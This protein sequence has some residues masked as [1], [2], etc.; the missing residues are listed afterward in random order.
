MSDSKQFRPTILNNKNN[1]EIFVN[2]DDH[3][4]LQDV[5]LCLA[6]MIKGVMNKFIL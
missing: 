3:I 4:A 6:M 2:T 1:R 5:Q